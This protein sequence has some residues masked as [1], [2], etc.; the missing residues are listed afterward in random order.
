VKLEELICSSLA[1]PG[2]AGNPLSKA[3]G[4]RRAEVF[5]SILSLFSQV[6]SSRDRASDEIA[7]CP[8]AEASPSMAARVQRGILYTVL[9]ADAFFFYKVLASARRSIRQMEHIVPP[10]RSFSLESGPDEC[11]SA[12]AFEA[13]VTVHLLAGSCEQRRS[14]PEKSWHRLFSSHNLLCER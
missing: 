4:V 13:G 5:S 10:D 6:T 9:S 1:H 11:H 7:R 3:M 12:A 8:N 2:V 14:E